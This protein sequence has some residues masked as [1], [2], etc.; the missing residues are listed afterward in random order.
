MPDDAMTHALPA[1]TNYTGKRCH[2]NNA[3][4]APLLIFIQCY[5]VRL[6]MATAAWTGSTSPL[7]GLHKAQFIQMTSSEYTNSPYTFLSYSIIRYLYGGEGTATDTAIYQRNV[8]SVSKKIRL[9]RGLT[10]K[11]Y[12]YNEIDGIRDPHGYQR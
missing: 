10:I 1:C 6:W 9:D 7:Q 5:S 8:P 12:A 2:I 4:V 11:I 3:Y